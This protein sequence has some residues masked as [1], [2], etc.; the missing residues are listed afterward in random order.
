MVGLLLFVTVLSWT[1]P[2]A[3]SEMS[4]LLFTSVELLLGGVLVGVAWKARGSRN[5]RPREAGDSCS[6]PLASRCPSVDE[7]IVVQP[8]SKVE[9]EKDNEAVEESEMRLVK[10]MVE[11]G[12]DKKD[13]LPKKEVLERSVGEEEASVPPEQG[14]PVLQMEVVEKMPAPQL[15]VEEEPITPFT[16]SPKAWSPRRSRG[17]LENDKKGK[18]R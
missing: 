13:E 8:K 17:N 15:G 1:I 5:S 12:A 10:D 9:H 6:V 11:G 18:I 2:A 3:A 4:I 14:Q 16:P 7:D